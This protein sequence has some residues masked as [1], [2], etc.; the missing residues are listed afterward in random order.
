M[1]YERQEDFPTHLRGWS[2]FCKFLTFSSI[3]V[4]VILGLMAIFLL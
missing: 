4:V 3:G 2:G 1:A